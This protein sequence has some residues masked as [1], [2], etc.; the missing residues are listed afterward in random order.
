MI[1]VYS[2]FSILLLITFTRGNLDSIIGIPSIARCGLECVL[3][4]IS[5]QVYWRDKY[6]KDFN[7]NL[8][9]IIAITWIILIMNYYW[10][11]LRSL[12]DWLIP[13][14]FY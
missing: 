7:L 12:H 14:F 2:L 9:A 5:Y 1:Y 8:L 11:H 4:I 6:K 10:H 13:A 3:G